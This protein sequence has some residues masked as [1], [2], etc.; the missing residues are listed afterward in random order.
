MDG[1]DLDYLI[2][3]HM[4]PD[5]GAAIVQVLETYPNVTVVGNSKTFDM[6]DNF[7]QL[8]PEKRLEV[9]EGDELCLGR[10][11]L[12]F[13]FAV[14]IHWPEVM[15]TY[16]PGDKVLFSA[17]AFGSFGAIDGSIFAD[18]QDFESEFLSEARRYYTNIVGMYGAQVQAVLKK[19]AGLEPNLSE[20]G[21]LSHDESV[22]ELRQAD[23]LILPLRKEPEYRKVLPGKIF[24]YLAARKPVLGIGQEDGAAAKLLSD[25]GAGTMLDW[26]RTEAMA[27]F[28]SRVHDGSF[29][30]AG[31]G[32]G[33][34]SRLSLTRKMTELFDSL[35]V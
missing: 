10:H 12:K 13:V 33:A 19:A 31:T 21:Y 26:P 35:T 7:Y 14:M 23:M 9:K 22:R 1:R 5:H 29:T 11:T 2:I 4:E 27:D 32:I 30:A 20:L 28:I 6:L 18:T 17:D 8:K 34:Y 16:D 25:A 3:N 15:F 24:E